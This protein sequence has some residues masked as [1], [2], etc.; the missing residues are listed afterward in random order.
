M[1]AMA[2]DDHAALDGGF[3]TV[4]QVDLVQVVVVVVVV[5]VVLRSRLASVKLIP[6]ALW[7][8]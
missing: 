2:L 3:G 1:D 5:V 6:V 7:L 4:L 8:L